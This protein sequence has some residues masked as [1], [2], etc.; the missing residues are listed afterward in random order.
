MKDA[1]AGSSFSLQPPSF[2]QPTARAP[3]LRAC[4]KKPHIRWGTQPAQHKQ[5]TPQQQ[6]GSSSTGDR[7]LVQ[8]LGMGLVKTVGVL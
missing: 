2:C 5:P 6:G 8:K 3:R 1:T 7:Q 4:K